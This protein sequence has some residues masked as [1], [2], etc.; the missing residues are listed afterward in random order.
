MR[1]ISIALLILAAHGVLSAQEIEVQAFSTPR[2]IEAKLPLYPTRELVRGEEGLVRVD[3]MVNTDG[4]AFD[5]FVADHV[6]SEGFLEAALAALDETRFQPA[7]RGGEPIVG[8]AS[9]LY[10]FEME[11]QS[12]GASET[13]SGLYRNFQRASRNEDGERMD[14]ALA[15]LERHGAKNRYEN[16]FLDLARYQ[17][18]LL[19]GSEIE[20][21]QY[22]RG[23]LST[24]SMPDDPV[25]LDA[26]V[27]RELRRL[28]LPLQMRNN[29]FSEALDTYALMQ[30]E[31]DEE[32]VSFFADAI[33]KV[34]ALEFDE[35]EYSLPLR[36][37]ASGDVGVQLF[38]H[39]IAVTGGT[40]ALIEMSLRCEQHYIAFE[41]ERD[42]YY[43]VPDE[44][45]DCS[46]Q[47]VGDTGAEFVLLQR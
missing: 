25:Y 10:R 18:A 34:K 40:G 44:W 11:E 2:S 20:Q 7:M 29:Y 3:F 21:M 26:D 22:L 4:T 13:F 5:P 35:T 42:I 17:H 14:D 16:A 24:S 15:N 9:I 41:I 30:A 47:I 32:A 27:A 46:A 12:Q 1:R 31:G 8:S 33:T 23:A 36:I 43:E 19:F 39:S 45:G 28:L 38:K 6:G 37:G